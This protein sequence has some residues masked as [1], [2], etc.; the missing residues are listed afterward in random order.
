[1]LMAYCFC[2]G[3]QSATNWDGV[4]Q[5]RG[6]QVQNLVLH[7]CFVRNNIGPLG[8]R[9]VC[10]GGCIPKLFILLGNIGFCLG[11]YNFCF[12]RRLRKREDCPMEAQPSARFPGA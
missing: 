4:Q 9:R 1:M 12:C 5:A 11:W 2:F 10:F 6:L 8:L 7:L 3:S